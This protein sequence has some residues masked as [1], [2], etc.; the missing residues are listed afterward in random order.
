MGNQTKNPQPKSL[1]E[2]AAAMLG[3]CK[4]VTLASISEDGC[5][6][7]CVLAKIASK[8]YS[9][10][11]MATATDSVKVSDFKRNPKAGLNYDDGCYGVTL[12]GEVEV[13]TNDAT[14]RK[15][16]QDWLINHFP[17]GP[18]DLTYTLLHFT[19]RKAVIYIGKE[20]VHKDI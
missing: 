1:D 11:W 9:D 10:V 3:R 16:W 20:F 6:R 17:Q 14:R 15:M 7:P 12:T 18:A 8:G 2:K 4:V 19:G 13:V 5:P